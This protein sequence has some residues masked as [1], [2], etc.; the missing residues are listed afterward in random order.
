MR[1]GFSTTVWANSV[2]NQQF[3]GIGV[4]TQA[5]WRSLLDQADAPA[6]YP[7]SFGNDFPEMPCGCPKRLAAHY[8]FSAV[9]STALNRTLPISK[10]VSAQVEL[11]HATDHYI[12]R[13]SGVPVVATVMD[14]IP[15]LHPEWVTSRFRALK[16][17]IFRESI[18]S[19]DHV[20]TI[21]EYSKLDMVRHLGMNPA[22][23]SVTTLGADP[24]YFQRIDPTVRGEVLIRHSL[25]PGFFL[26][27]G[28]L[29]PRKNL[30][31]T[32]RAHQ[33]LPASLRKR[34][35]LVVVGRNGWGVDHLLPELEAME[36][37][38][39]GRWLKYLPQSDVL[40]LLQSAQALL[41]PSLYEGF[42]LPVI[43]AF[44][45]QAPVICSNSTSLPEVAGD[46]ALMVDPFDAQDIARG[47]Q[48]LLGD[49][50]SAALRVQRGYLRAGEFTWSAC[51]EQTLAV[52]HKVL[53]ERSV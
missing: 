46:A 19:S 2:R 6:L 15:M 8:S 10:S 44:A 52:Y 45:A 43:E 1:I 33:A 3:D 9:Q 50:E 49:P 17:W 22:Q 29:Q 13:L 48:E 38:G 24:V 42:G 41:F 36:Q 31:R 30:E 18:L 32:L 11:F 16:N 34:H 20:I 47:M 35:P 27:I 39:E 5:L 4:Y 53:A 25:Q 37:R 14:L 26:F 51:A 28:T 21:S 23:I 12:P 40:A 7:Y